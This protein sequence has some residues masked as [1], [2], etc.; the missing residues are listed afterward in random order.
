[1]L[2]I[3]VEVITWKAV[4]RIHIVDMIFKKLKNDTLSYKYLLIGPA[5]LG[6]SANTCARAGTSLPHGLGG[7]AEEAKS[8]MLLSKGLKLLGFRGCQ[9]NICGFNE[10]WM[11]LSLR[12]TEHSSN[13]E[14]TLTGGSDGWLPDYWM[15]DGNER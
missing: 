14:S 6:F 15:W 13:R 12:M 8:P 3:E 5:E 7:V 1:M 9:K 11:S 2:R 10:A 4:G